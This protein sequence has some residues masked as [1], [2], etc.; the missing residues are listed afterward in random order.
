MENKNINKKKSPPVFVYALG[1]LGEVGK[2]SYVIE[3]G[4]EI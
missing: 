2:N 1:G 4:H 3:S